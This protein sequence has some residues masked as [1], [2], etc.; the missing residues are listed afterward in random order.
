MTQPSIVVL[1]GG[2]SGMATAY[3]LAR[4]GYG[5]ITILE[6]GSAVGGLAGSFEREG[7]SYPL[8]YHHIL[9][10]DR[11][12]LWFLHDIGALPRVRWRRVR[13][14]FFL[15]GRSFDLSNPLDFWRFPMPLADKARFVR[16]ML[17]AFA[18]SDW[19]EYEDRSA[20]ELL[21]ERAS[22]G[23]REALF[24][25]LTRLKFGLSCA[26]VSG[27]WL[28]ERLSFREGSAPLGYIPGTNWTS[29]LCKRL[30]EHIRG[31][32]VNVRVRSRV[33]RVHSRERRVVAAELE[34]G[35]RVSADLFV[36]GLP[37]PAYQSLLPNDETEGLAG[38]RYSSLISTICGTYRHPGRDFYWLNVASLDKT[39][40]AVFLLSSLNPTITPKGQTCVNFVT[41]LRAPEGPFLLSDDELVDRYKKDYA[42]LF[43]TEL[44]PLWTQVNR[45]KMYSPIFTPRYRN[46]PVRSA[47]FDN[48]FFTGNYRT[49]PSIMS[50]GTAL[51][52][53][54]CTA[55]AILASLGRRSDLSAQIEGFKL[56]RMPRAFGA[57]P[58]LSGGR[59]RE[60][61]ADHG[62]VK[63]NPSSMASC[64]ADT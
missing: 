36:S 45:V 50:T 48:L 20:A 51:R 25:R 7:R 59:P 32:G 34:N 30:D 22:P 52:S 11:A 55:D 28:G 27:S 47:S 58:G 57:L 63:D 42:E 2:L 29:V 62:G 1:G 33:A 23:V 61:K 53:G 39:A 5:K 18:R 40:C 12:L 60:R 24:E 17:G 6:S 13:M 14:L 37:T 3:S 46:P 9:H 35:E 38:I 19:S 16:L 41:H 4:A 56:G 26:E 64:W 43:G 49:H 21:D 10:K 31:L 44:C 15:D 8:G 54:V